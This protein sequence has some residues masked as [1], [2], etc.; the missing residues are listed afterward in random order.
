MRNAFIILVGCMLLNGCV[1]VVYQDYYS[2]PE[3]CD[4]DGGQSCSYVHMEGSYNYY[5]MPSILCADI[6]GS[7][8]SLFVKLQTQDSL[9]SRIKAARLNGISF[10]I[11]ELGWSKELKEDKHL[12][13][14]ER[15]WECKSYS[16]AYT[17]TST[18]FLSPICHDIER[19]PFIIGT[20][21]DFETSPSFVNLA[22]KRSIYVPKGRKLEAIQII[23][24]RQ[25]MMADGRLVNESCRDVISLRR[26][27]TF[28]P[29]PAILYMGP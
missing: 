19:H 2:L 7:P 28:F 11:E 21:E 18:R 4:Q 23:Y 12:F 1:L 29:W 24:E 17:S 8:F 9:N 14:D 10:Y 5:G 26:K 22:G 27:R 16:D 20:S 6:H 25:V 13:P 3:Y 15:Y